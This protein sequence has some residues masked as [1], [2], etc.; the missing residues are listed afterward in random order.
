MDS[1]LVTKT[2]RTV[3]IDLIFTALGKEEFFNFK[4]IS[5]FPMTSIL[6]YYIGSVLVMSSLYFGLYAGYQLLKEMQQGTFTRLRTTKTSFPL[7]V[8]AKLAVYLGL[9]TLFTASALF[10][11]SRRALSIDIIL[12]CV[13]FA[14]FSICQAVFL[15]ALFGTVQ[16]FILIGNLLL[17]YFSIIGGGIIPIQFLP[18]DMLTL[19]RFTPFY[20]I[21]RSILN[22]SQGQLRGISTATAGFIMISIG[23][24]CIAVAILHRRSVIHDD[25]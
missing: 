14:M 13:A 6:H 20:Y 1:S 19:S 17:F 16:R 21:L 7:F 18:Q 22:I 3:S 5:Q 15:C 4:P 24:Y 9:L 25:I 12:S 23:L 2:N 8:T 11:L 10:L